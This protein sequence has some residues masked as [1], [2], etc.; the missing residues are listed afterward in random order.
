MVRY[1][2][3]GRGSLHA[4]IL[5]WVHP[6]DISRVGDE[7]TASIPVSRQVPPGHT[8]D[9][10]ADHCSDPQQE[11]LRL[12]VLRKQIH[13]CRTMPGGCRHQ[14]DTCQHGFPF[15]PNT[16]GTRLDPEYGK[17]YIYFRAD[18]HDANVV[19]YHPLVLLL[20]NAHMNIQVRIEAAIIVIPN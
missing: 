6:D 15:A 20:W 10:F 19:P 12:L 2:C 13:A 7:I 5:L 3:Q 17:R 9:P 16:A 11:R 8:A 18:E 1:E 4:H 14:R